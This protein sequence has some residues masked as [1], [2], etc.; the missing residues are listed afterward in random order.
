MKKSKLIL[1]FVGLAY[2]F[3][4]YNTDF[5]IDSGKY[6]LIPIGIFFAIRFLSKK[7]DDPNRTYVQYDTPKEPYQTSQV[8]MVECE[9]CGTMNNE[10]NALCTSCNGFIK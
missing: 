3:I 2:V 4:Q 6:A 9:Y 7:L 10:N 1:I 5:K 8:K